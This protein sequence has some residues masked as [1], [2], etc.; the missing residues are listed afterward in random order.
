MTKKHFIEQAK[1]IALIADLAD[2]KRTAETFALTNAKAN[3][4]FDREKFLK[5]C[6]I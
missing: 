6:G 4:R 5:A 3:P 1:A 2:R